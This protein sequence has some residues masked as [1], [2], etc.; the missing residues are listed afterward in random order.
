MASVGAPWPAVVGV[1]GGSDSLAL[2]F[3]LSDWARKRR[4]RAPIVLCVDHA[5]RAESASEARQ[6]AAW[7]QAA[8]LAAHVL[9][10]AR[11]I[12]AQS[13]IEAACRALRFR[14]IGEWATKHKM[15]AIYLAHTLD[16]QAETFLLRL[17]R[18][19]GVDGLSGMRPVA[20]Y[21][22]PAF[23]HLSL[24]RPLLRF[25]RDDLRAYLEETGRAWLE[26]PMNADVRFARTRIR[27]AWPHLEALGLTRL[28]LA[29]AA[30]HLG[31]AR[32]A[33]DAASQ[34]VIVRAFRPHGDGA[35]VDCRALSEAPR[36]LGLRALAGI[37]MLVGRRTYRPRFDSLEALF[38]SL[39]AERI[40]NGRTLHG[41]RI[42][43]APRKYAVF[44]SRTLLVRP[45]KPRKTLGKG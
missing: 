5:V 12:A 31:R 43:P 35:A 42:A 15:R 24:V 14:L 41:C 28:R 18:G 20:R 21:P 38:D 8:G 29:D 39:S 16:D 2:M 17:A 32:A 34:A 40:G 1:S 45:E 13:D 22:D 4:L 30:S 33:L 19:S 9:R 11:P 3:L 44:G 36:E 37:L 6:V 25:R 27:Q 10:S 23:P 7:A 26:D